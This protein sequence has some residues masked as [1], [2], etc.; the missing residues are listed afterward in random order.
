M[1]RE[2]FRNTGK[3]SFFGDMVYDRVVHQEH[4]LRKLNEVV[5]G[6]PITQKCCAAKTRE[7]SMAHLLM[8]RP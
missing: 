6:R 1:P 8:N 3:S 5:D 7:E 4:F 2:R